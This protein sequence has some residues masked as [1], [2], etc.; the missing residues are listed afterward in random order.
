MLLLRC[1]ALRL[2]EACMSHTAL[3]VTIICCVALTTFSLWGT[4]A[5][6]SRLSPL[7]AVASDLEARASFRSAA[8][9][10]GHACSRVESN[11]LRFRRL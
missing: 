6:L 1:R 5:L 7:G 2:I 9:F 3:L 4:I 8:R 11:S 10:G